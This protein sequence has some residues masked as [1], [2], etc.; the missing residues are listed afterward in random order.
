MKYFILFMVIFSLILAC[1]SLEQLIVPPTVKVE[2]VD[3]SNFS[4]DDVTFDFGLAINNSNPFGVSI[5][6]YDY[7]FAVQGKEFLSANE[8]RQF[9]INAASSNMIT[10]PITVN[11]KSLFD[12]MNKVKDMDSLSYDLSGH[13]KPGGLLAGFNIPFHTK[14][15]FPNVRIPELAFKGL[16]IKKLD[17]RGVNL[18]LGM[19]IANSNCFAFDIGSLIYNISLAG[20]P[21]AQGKADQLASIP[22]K[23][24][25]DIALP[26]ALDFSGAASSLL[27]VLRG[28]V[29]ECQIN[30]SSALNTP[31][32]VVTLP[33][34]MTRNIDILR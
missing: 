13:L 30:G 11:F 9:T 19:S 5:E 15:N 33:I 14:G 21:V 31:F 23:G 26:I 34:E 27:P 24:K 29:V 32:G 6:G 18:E 25:G 10:L 1:T 3:I 20:K 22:A 4:F 7:Q 28:N 2:H 12:L 8:N 17:L 16:K